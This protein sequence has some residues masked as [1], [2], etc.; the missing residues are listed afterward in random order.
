MTDLRCPAHPARLFAKVAEP[1]PGKHL[2]EVACDRCRAELR[3]SGH[4]VVRVLHV[5][6]LDGGLVHSSVVWAEGVADAHR[7]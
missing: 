4:L 1:I 7:Q 6:D 5:Y 3:R 2:V